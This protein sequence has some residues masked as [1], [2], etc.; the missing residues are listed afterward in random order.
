[1]KISEYY[2]KLKTLIEE[3]VVITDWTLSLPQL[4]G[5][6]NA[7]IAPL[8]NVY[9]YKN[10]STNT[11]ASG[12]QEVILTYV[13]DN[14][15]P[16]HSINMGF[17]Q[18]IYNDVTMR[19]MLA[20]ERLDVM[21]IQNNAGLG[22][23]LS[24]MTEGMGYWLVTMRFN[25]TI[26]WVA[27]YETYQEERY[28]I[29]RINSS[30]FRSKVSED[31]LSHLE[32]ILDTNLEPFTL[33]EPIP[34]PEPEPIPEPVVVV[35]PILI[36]AEDFVDSLD[37]TSG[38]QGNAFFR[39]YGDVDVE[40]NF[41]DVTN[42]GYMTAGEWLEYSVTIPVTG[43]YKVSARLASDAFFFNGIERTLRFTTGSQ[44]S[45]VTTSFASSWTEYF[46]YDGTGSFT[47]SAG[48]HI[49]RATLMNDAFNFDNF[50]LTKL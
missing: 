11:Y 1:M 6:S 42:I 50:K 15:I 10:N 46:Y 9:Y 32:K 18:G 13:V 3:I 27:E 17:F 36:E 30:L 28:N 31:K 19:L 12:T 48:V 8:T 47:L 34:E 44:T 23:E 43:N 41:V 29:D 24:E 5:E 25:I 4:P 22:V 35:A 16:Y 14:D 45:D 33:P 2:Q 38:N 40:T 7:F 20:T 26:Q 39:D 37:L 49:V 21:N